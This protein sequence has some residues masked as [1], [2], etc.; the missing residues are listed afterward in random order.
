MIIMSRFLQTLAFYLIFQV[1][2]FGQSDSSTYSTGHISTE[3]QGVITVTDESFGCSDTLVVNIPAGNYV[4][5]VDVYYNIEAPIA[6]NGWVS[7]QGSYLQFINNQTKETAISFGDPNWDSAGVFSYSRQGLNIANGTSVSGQLLFFLHAFRTFG[8]APACGTNFQRVVDSTWKIVVH[9]IPPPTCFEPT[10]LSASAVSTSSVSLNWTTGG[11]TNW[12]I[13]YRQAGSITPFTIINAS[14]NPFTVNG[15]SA[16]VNYEFQVRDSCGTGDVSIWHGTA[17][18]TTFCNPVTAPYSENF[19]GSSW[20]TGAGGDNL[21]NSIDVCWVRPT[22]NPNFGARAGGTASGA[23]GPATDFGGGGKYLYTEAS[24]GAT[25]AGEINSLP[26]YIPNSMVNPQLKFY[27]HMFGADITSLEVQVDNGSGFGASLLTIAGQQQTSS[28]AAWQFDTLGLKAFKGDTVVIKF[29]GTNSGF[30]GDIAIDEFSIAEAP[31]CFPPDTLFTINQSP[32]SIA[33]DWNSGGA[34]R[35]LIGYRVN[36]STGP[37]SYFAAATKPRAVTAL[38][39]GTTYQFFIKDSCGAGNTSVWSNP[40]T[41]TTR[42]I[43][44]IAPYT[45][46]FDGPNWTSGTG[47]LNA[48]NVEDVCWTRPTGNPNFGTRTGATGSGASGPSG[49]YNVGGN[50]LFTEASN[51]AVGTGEITSVPIFIPNTMTKPQLRFYYHMFGADITSLEVQID[52]GFGFGASLLTISGQQQTASADA[53]RFDTLTLSAYKGDTILIKFLGTNSGF[54]G[55]IAIDEFSIAE[56]PTCFDPDSLAIISTTSSSAE[57][58]WIT[59]GSANWLIG[60][61]VNGSTGPLTIVPAGTNPFVVTGLS[62]AT[63]YEFFVKD[64]CAVGDVSGWSTPIIAGTECSISI[65]P[66]SE[67]F[68]GTSWVAGAGAANANNQIDYCWDR[69][70][71]G[72]PDFGTRTGG[73]VSTATGPAADN[74]GSGKY[75]YTEAS[76]GALGTGEITTPWVVVSNSIVSPTLEFY[77]HMYGADITSLEVQVDRGQGFGASLKT[78]TGAQQISSADAWKSDTVDLNTYKGDTIRI[79]F[80]GTNSGFDGDIAIDDVSIDEPPACLAPQNLALDYAWVNT[81]SITWLSGGANTWQLQHGPTGFTLGSGT[82]TGATIN[83]GIITG[84]S[85]ATTYD[86]YVRDSCAPGVVSAWV[87]PLTFTTLCAST[88]VPFSENFDSIPWATGGNNFALGIIGSCWERNPLTQFIWK[89]GPAPAQST[90]S[91]TAN[92]HTTG[93]DQFI[94]SERISVPVNGIVDAYIQTPPIVISGLSNPQLTFWYHMYGNSLVGL[95]VDINTGSGWTGIYQKVGQQQTSGT[96]P[97]KEAIVNLSAYIGDTV[98]IRFKS[99]NN[100]GGTNNDV[101][102]DD[103]EIDDAPSCPKPQDIKV[104]GFTNTSATIGWTAGGTATNWNI[105][106]GTPGFTL[107]TGT[108]INATT[109]PFT[110]TG[111][112]PNTPY[113]FYVRDSCGL[114]DVSVWVGSDSAITDC[115]PVA[116]PLIENFDGAAWV[117][118]TPGTID[119]CWQRYP[120]SGYY[121]RVG[122]NGTPTANTGPSSDNTTGNGKYLYAETD[123]IFGGF[124]PNVAVFSTPLVDLSTLTTPE[125]KFFYHLYGADIDSMQVRVFN[126]TSWTIVQSFTSQQ[127]SSSTDAWIEQIVDLS[128]FSGNTIK[129]EFR[130]IKALGQSLLGDMAIDDISINEKPLCPKPSNLAFLSATTTTIDIG[131]TSGGATNWLVEY[132]PVGFTPGTG[133]VI[134]ASTNPYTVSG[135]SPSSSYDFYVRDS[136]GVGSISDSVGPVFGATLCGVRSAPYLETFDGPNFDPGPA[137]FGIPGTIDTCWTRNTTATYFWKAGPSTPQT[138]GTGSTIGDHTSGNGQY[139]FTESGGFVGPPLNAEANTPPID[140]SPLTAPELRYWYHMF[141]PNVNDLYVEISNNGGLSY[142]TIDTLSGNQQATQAS[143][144]LE[145]IV[146]ISAY[147]NDTVIIKFRAEK[148]S[149]GNQSDISI[150]DI[151]IDEAPSCPDPTNLVVTGR[152]SFTITLDWV[153]GGATNWN[154]QYGPTGFQLGQGTTVMVSSKPYTITNLT[155]QTGYC[156]YVQDSCGIGDVS[157]WI[158]ITDTTACAPITVPWTENFDGPDWVSGAGATNAGNS[159]SDCWTRPSAANPN[160]GTRTGGTNSAGTG[161]NNDVSGTGNYIY[162]EASGAPGLGSITSPF[163]DIPATVPAATLNFSHHMFGASIDSL[164]VSVS[165]GGAFARQFS[166]AGQQQV[167]NAAAWST[168]SVDLS[169]FIGNNIQIRFEGTNSGFASDIAIDEISIDTNSCPI[170]TALVATASTA[171]TISLNWITGGATNWLV[172]YR[173][174]GSTGPLTIVSATTNP[175]VLG[176]LTASSTYDIYVKDSCSAGSVSEWVGPVTYITQCGLVTA[177]FSENFDGTNWTSGVGAVNNGNIISSC[178]ARPA[179]TNPNFGTRTGVTLSAGS[180]PSADVSGLGNYL[181]TEASGGATGTGEITTPSIYIPASMVNPELV[182]SYHMYGADITNLE[183]EVDNGSGFTNILTITGQQQT[184]STSPWAITSVN[185]SAYSGDTLLIKFKGTNTGFNGDIAIDEVTVEDI[186]CPIPSNLQATSSASNSITLTWTTGGATN[187]LVGY[188]ELGSAGG[189]TIVPASTNPFVLS[190][191]V[192]SKTYELLVKDSCGAADV[193][194]WIGPITYATECG[195]IT[196]PYI[197]SFD[198]NRWITG[199][200]A[201]NAGDQIDSCWIRSTNTGVRWTTGTG[202]TPSNGTGPVS[203]RGGNGNYIYTEASIGT[204]TVEIQSPAIYLPTSLTNP[205]LEYW[206][207]MFGNAVSSLSVEV[208]NGGAFVNIGTISGQQQTAN[209]DAWRMDTINLSSYSGDTIVLKFIGV[210]TAFAGDISVDDVSIN[211]V[212]Q[213]NDPTMLSITNI[214]SFGAQ[215]N[216]TSGSAISELEVVPAGQP[217]GT[218]TTYSPATSPYILSGLTASTLY[219]IYVRDLCGTI[220]SNWVTDTFTTLAPPTV[221]L[222][223]TLVAV[224]AITT[225]SA[226]LNWTSS[227]SSI[228]SEVE[229]LLAG[230]P[231]GTGT[232]YAPAVS[233]LAITGLLSNTGYDVYVRDSCGSVSSAWVKDSFMTAACPTVVGSFIFSRSILNGTFD[234]TASIGATSY[235]WDFGDGNSGT[236]VNISH[237]YANAGT[238][239]V[240]MIAS[241]GC[242]NADTVIQSIQVCDSLIADFTYSINGDTVSF[243]ASSST[244]A[245]SYTWDLNGFG[246]NGQSVNYRFPSPGTKP[247]TLTVFNECGDSARVVKN[248]KVCLA[249]KASWTYNIISTTSAGMLTQFDASASQNAVSYEWNFGDASALVTGQIM[250]QHTYIT[251]GLFYKVTLKVTNTCGE[252]SIQSYRLSQIGLEEITEKPYFNFYPNPAHQN[253]KVEWDVNSFG[254]SEIEIIDASGKVVVKDNLKQASEGAQTVDISTLAKG[255]YMIRMNTDSGVIQR[256]LIIE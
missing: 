15:L 141:G 247:V 177:P 178:W 72:N 109:N 28:A 123:F 168:A 24:N 179:A 184:A 3:F 20:I 224:S 84:L 100:N 171:G 206:Y 87:G 148:T 198:N 21:G 128:P 197:E 23:T 195:V 209:N 227:T 200:G 92:D 167:S 204:G 107:G 241:N 69:P 88:G 103:V 16:G 202:G 43:S 77:Y 8:G 85:A 131:W 207:H 189:Y 98:V 48:G 191:L 111:L 54:N 196:A 5:G 203:D 113:E 161:P 155:P 42:C 243:D 216:W 142:T 215:V 157:N 144:W 151:S 146:D 201:T 95:E 210:N 230:Q 134:P 242:G 37:L 238:Y 63:I 26:V 25:G 225:N 253:I 96:D 245:T 139:L 218:G 211:G 29:I 226:Q 143:P 190:G 140:L 50:Y 249:P 108:V 9:H 183:V 222:D 65:A 205:I 188:R 30:N 12:Q 129:V 246:A 119:A 236:G 67:S 57:L 223:P 147:A 35:W 124:N 194:E 78:I 41:A 53:W 52:N 102:I 93:N 160:F 83:P 61:R 181:Y 114:A 233:P 116:A 38:M 208:S 214:G 27:Y 255:Y 192:A 34:S 250:P 86:V 137:G 132:G 219:D 169:A 229:V 254:A 252:A 4:T 112:S 97:W 176:G 122:Q 68:D 90:F 10:A 248:V 99:T 213:C 46:N 62:P 60:Y 125:L 239:I 162:T 105:E 91:G 182:F 117:G 221:C 174:A 64:S 74:S 6:G 240:I 152:T 32:T 104:I 76:G 130:A 17:R 163:I 31:T 73:T 106:Y 156:F 235:S 47:A 186:S 44:V 199:A 45:E 121:F 120:T 164:V 59:G 19:D 166:L 256:K 11:A 71:N 172:G 51:G 170:P 18:A 126:G 115:N 145:A 36:G 33:L 133:I 7:E 217:Q 187:W 154:I 66:W 127:Q 82:I 110:V 150:D 89:T 173:A 231:P 234:G 58:S 56:A 118:G 79:R 14:S 2:S 159:I 212:I 40:I 135:L 136:C 220:S 101:S 1:A 94:Y 49:D 175:F 244:N 237:P 55:D 228:T 149:N 80:L 232:L 153:T 165:T 138:A 13:G 185:L 70:S 39:P 251:P 75:L 180:G 81:A 22:G 158:K 193:S